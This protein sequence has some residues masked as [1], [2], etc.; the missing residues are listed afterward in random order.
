MRPN[1]QHRINGVLH[2]SFANVRLIRCWSFCLTLS[3]NF[4]Q[5]FTKQRLF[6][7]LNGSFLSKLNILWPKCP[8]QFV[9]KWLIILVQKDPIFVKIT[10]TNDQHRIITRCI[11]IRCWSFCLTLTLMLTQIFIKKRLFWFKG[12]V[13]LCLKIHFWGQKDLYAWTCGALPCSAVC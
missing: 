7:G 5:I 10:R 13:Y 6:L 3:L 1:D 4:T 2:H 11:A 12:V 8:I 9:S